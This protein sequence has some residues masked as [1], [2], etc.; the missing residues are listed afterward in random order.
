[1]MRVPLI[2]VLPEDFNC[3]SLVVE[4]RVCLLDIM[5]TI[6]DMTG[7]PESGSGEGLSLLPA[8]RGE[9]LPERMLYFEADDAENKLGM[10]KNQ[11]KYIF[12][13]LPPQEKRFL[14]NLRFQH[15]LGA[16]VKYKSEEYYNLNLD[17]KELNN[18]FD[19][20]DPGL[21]KD[22]RESAIDS[23]L[24]RYN[25]FLENKYQDGSY[26]TEE[27]LERLRALGYVH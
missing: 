16:I 5:P 12:N 24:F 13:G 19:E 1:M 23:Y 21:K 11:G 6:L 27:E 14:P 9:S 22:L 2:I 10:L 7:L 18:I 25:E 26:L 20:S 4:D 8:I 17:S 15:Y 3:H